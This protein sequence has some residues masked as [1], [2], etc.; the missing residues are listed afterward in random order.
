MQR[1]GHHAILNWI[2]GHYETAR[3][4]NDISSLDESRT[5]KSSGEGHCDISNVEDHTIADS[6]SVIKDKLET[7]PLIILVVRDPYNL[8]A[9]RLSARFIVR[10]GDI[11]D[12]SKAMWIDHAKSFIGGRFFGI[13]YNEWFTNKE[14]R[15]KIAEKLSLDYNEDRLLQVPGFGYGSSF[16]ET[17]YNDNAKSMKVLERWR[18]HIKNAEYAEFIRDENLTKLSSKIFDPCFF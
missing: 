3:I 15:M 16:D 4:R 9:S 6:L 8:F 11:S 12:R 13:S 5:V 1:S 18:Q 10:S 7:D 17:K 2:A 14:Y